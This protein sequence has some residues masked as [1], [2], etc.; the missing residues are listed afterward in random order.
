MA[1][2]PPKRDPG[3]RREPTTGDGCMERRYPHS[4]NSKGA[5]GSVVVKSACTNGT[6]CYFG[7]AFTEMV[8]KL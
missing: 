4:C 7:G 5:G 6:V 3:R 2:S 1:N 8:Q